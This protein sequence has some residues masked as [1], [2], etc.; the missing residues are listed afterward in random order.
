MVFK[1]TLEYMK[2]LL[3]SDCPGG[4]ALF[5]LNRVLPR[6]K[7]GEEEGVTA[8]QQS[9]SDLEFCSFDSTAESPLSLKTE[10]KP[11]KSFRTLM[12]ICVFIIRQLCRFR[13]RK[14]TFVTRKGLF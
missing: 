7:T 4:G 9:I 1:F 11:N 8:D 3:S 2:I 14:E 12:K 10:L 5:Q 6:A 13:L